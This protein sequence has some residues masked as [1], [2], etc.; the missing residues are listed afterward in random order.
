MLI[1][2]QDLCIEEAQD[3][4]L[5]IDDYGC[6]GIHQEH[7]YSIQKINNSSVVFSFIAHFAFVFIEF[8]VSSLS[9]SFV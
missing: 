9:L 3:V 7:K 2:G 4:D 6:V 1:I 8:S 5:D